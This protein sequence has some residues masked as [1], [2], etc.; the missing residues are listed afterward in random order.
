MLLLSGCSSKNGIF[1]D[2]FEEYVKSD[3]NKT[4]APNYVKDSIDEVLKGKETINLDNPK[5]L[6]SALSNL[7]N[8]DNN[9]YVLA[10]GTEDIFLKSVQQSHQLGIDSFDK[11]NQYIQDTSNYFIYIKKNRFLK[12]RVRVVSI[13][14]KDSLKKNLQDIPFA[15]DGKMAVADILEELR[16]V[17]GFNIIAKNMPAEEKRKMK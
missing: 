16:S 2:D 11:L 17:S 4:Q 3:F 14:D 13:K 7:S 8:L 5:R 6:S 1:N 10:D 9:L 12:N 15:V